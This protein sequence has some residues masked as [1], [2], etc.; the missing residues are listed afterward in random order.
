MQSPFNKSLNP[1]LPSFLSINSVPQH[2]D[3]KMSLLELSLPV[4]AKRWTLSYLQDRWGQDAVHRKPHEFFQS[5]PNPFYHLNATEHT[6]TSIPERLR[7]PLNITSVETLQFMGFNFE[8]A[9]QIFLD[10]VE[11]AEERS[12]G[13]DLLWF[14]LQSITH[15]EILAEEADVRNSNNKED[16]IIMT[17]MGLS[18][19][20]FGNPGFLESID[21]GP[22]MENPIPAKVK[23]KK[24]YQQ[25]R[26]IA[27]RYDFIASF[28]H[29]ASHYL[30]RRWSREARPRITGYAGYNTED[31]DEFYPRDSFASNTMADQLARSSSNPAG[32]TRKTCKLVIQPSTPNLQLQR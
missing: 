30:H 11:H 14:A 32:R 4:I 29:T 8:K 16:Q 31:E 1:F 18:P 2:R 3:T 22:P 6:A 19:T 21:S 13:Q 7:I 28:N 27:R 24:I 12:P 25:V 23:H 20:E 9:Q 10:M 26:I 5:I 15:S 17:F